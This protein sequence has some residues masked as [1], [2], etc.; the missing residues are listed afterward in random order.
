MH[1]MSHL[2]AFFTTQLIPVDPAGT[3][4]TAGAPGLSHSGFSLVRLSCLAS[5]CPASS[6]PSS[7]IWSGTW[8]HKMACGQAEEAMVYKANGHSR[9]RYLQK[10]PAGCRDLWLCLLE[11]SEENIQEI[12]V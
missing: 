12:F 9:V 5:H 3:G 1:L 8:I 7:A 2:S 4:L 6:W 11:N 10:Q